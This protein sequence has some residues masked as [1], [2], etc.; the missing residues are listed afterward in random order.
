MAFEEVISDGEV[1]SA[2]TRRMCS[3]GEGLFS[4]WRL[5]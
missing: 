1:S 2:S 4:D 3:A 5:D